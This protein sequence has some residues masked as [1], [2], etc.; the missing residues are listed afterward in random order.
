[1]TWRQVF[2]I[3]FVRIMFFKIN[4]CLTCS[5]RIIC[6]YICAFQWGEPFAT[7]WERCSGFRNRHF[8]NAPIV[9]MSHNPLLNS[10]F[11]CSRS[12]ALWT[13]LC[14]PIPFPHA[15]RLGG[16]IGT[17]RVCQWALAIQVNGRHTFAYQSPIG[18][19]VSTPADCT[20]S[21][22]FLAPTRTPVRVPVK[23]YIDAT[24]FFPL[25]DDRTW[26]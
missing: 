18:C 7:P 14:R 3:T 8:P 16:A 25:H 12:A 13:P 20:A 9:I 2:E 26:D 6:M 24:W 5:T 21:W 1:M 19:D 22:F 15:D 23:V 17:G 4:L 10:S 11:L